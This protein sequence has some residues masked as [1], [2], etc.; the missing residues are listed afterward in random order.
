MTR[1]LNKFVINNYN[2]YRQCT[3][4]VMNS[5]L[6]KILILKGDFNFLGFL[7]PTRITWARQFSMNSHQPSSLCIE[8]E[9]HMNSLDIESTCGGI[10]LNATY[11]MP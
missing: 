4:G 9:Y 7:H 8:I 11:R 1:T 10:I 3:S 6:L 5:N 2:A